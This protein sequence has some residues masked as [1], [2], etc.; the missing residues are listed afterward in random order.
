[1]KNL[2]WAIKNFV[3][4][5]V[6]FFTIGANAIGPVVALVVFVF[7]GMVAGGTIDPPTLYRVDWLIATFIVYVIFELASIRL[8]INQQ[9][10]LM[11][12]DI[13]RRYAKE[14]GTDEI[15]SPETGNS[16]SG[17]QVGNKPGDLAI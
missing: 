10:I 17:P 2:K 7:C 3:G 15:E 4:F 14:F 12:F 13:S 5:V 8:L 1:M 16:Q 11:K 9:V 6:G